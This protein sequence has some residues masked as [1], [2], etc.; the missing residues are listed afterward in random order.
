FHQ[1]TVQPFMRFKNEGLRYHV[2]VARE[3]F[4]PQVVLDGGLE[5]SGSGITVKMED[6]LQVV[7]FSALQ[8]S[9]MKAGGVTFLVLPYEM[10][11]N[12]YLTG[13]DGNQRLIVSE[14]LVLE[15]EDKLSL[16]SDNQTEVGVLVYPAAKN[17]Q[18][19]N[20]R[21]TP[22]STELESLRGWTLSVD[23]QTP[24]MDLIASGDR[25][26]VLRAPELD[27]DHIN[28]VFLKFDYRGD[29]A[30]CMMNG[31]LVTDHLYTSAPWLVGLKRYEDQLRQHEMYFYF[32]PMK[33]DA[34]YLSW[35]D[36]EVLPDF[37]DA[38]E[39]LEVYEPEILVEY[40]FDIVL[41]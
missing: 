32:M 38:R 22:L 31:E 4:E 29:R 25:H 10:A 16:I 8:P 19:K 1:A 9:E 35:L 6:G 3:G 14:A 18:A 15:E 34:P 13:A 36:K 11:L 21:K 7:T 2:M 40:Q 27:F 5:V 33:R 23:K 17:L 12:A 20:S 26:F 28:D 41:Y 39:F 37:G 30:V 24:V